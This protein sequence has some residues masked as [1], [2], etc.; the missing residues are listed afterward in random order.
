VFIICREPVPE[1]FSFL[2][3]AYKW[4]V[5]GKASTLFARKKDDSVCILHQIPHA[6]IRPVYLTDKQRE[7]NVKSFT[8]LSEDE[9]NE[10]HDLNVRVLRTVLSRSQ[11]DILHANHLIY[12]PVAALEACNPIGTPF[13]IYPHGSSIEYV[14]KSDERYQVLALKALLGCGGLITGSREVHD[15]ITKLYPEYQDVINA[16]T[17][18][19]GVGVD[20]SLF[21]PVKK[22]ERDKNI[23]ALINTRGKGGKT[24]ELTDELFTRLGNLEIRATRDYWDKYDHSLPDADLNVRL[25]QIPWNENVLLFVGALTSGKGLQ[26][27]ITAL[28]AIL[29][30]HP[31]THLVI[32]GAGAYREVLEGLCYAITASNEALLFELCNNGLDLDRNELVGPWEDIQH[33]LKDPPNLSRLMTHGK[34]LLDHVFFLGRLD[35]SRL[36]Y[37]F[38]CSDLAVFPSII[39]E[40]YPLVLME[41]LANGVIPLVS[42]FSGFK[43]GLDELEPF[44]G[45]TM[46]EK[47]KIS[48]DPYQRIESIISNISDLLRE[49]D[50]EIHTPK[51]RRIAVENYDWR[52]RADQMVRAYSFFAQRGSTDS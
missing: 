24:P 28:P 47:L 19:V 13:V 30:Q 10:Y 26:S 43:D 4:D 17:K 7:G 52:I 16:K 42:Y 51:L 3:A 34:D 38:P 8:A 1:S 41:S 15:R 5:D 9:L 44:L 18:I 33:Y 23:Q 25:E 27:L 46:I 40:A 11:L 14:V 2:S 36:K 12:Q 37:L 29:S 22:T 35:H 45:T 32:V 6:Q 31:D 50:L 20:T 48:I 49:P 39:P 21:K